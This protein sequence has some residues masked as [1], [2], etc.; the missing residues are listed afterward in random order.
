MDK[1]EIERRGNEALGLVVDK[2]SLK[3]LTDHWAGLIF[4][5]LEMNPPSQRKAALIGYRKKDGSGYFTEMLLLG[6]RWDQ[7]DIMQGYIDAKVYNAF[8]LLDK[9]FYIDES[10]EPYLFHELMRGRI[11][12]PFWHGLP[13]T[14]E[15]EVKIPR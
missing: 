2:Q 15:V 3:G 11:P 12:S 7:P 14:V 4:I 10:V 13:A 1:Q 8:M 9:S 5:V 6:D